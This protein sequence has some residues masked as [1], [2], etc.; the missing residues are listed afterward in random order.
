MT[1][2]PSPYPPQPH[3]PGYQTPSTPTPSPR[4]TSVTVLA[5]I[6]IIFGGIGVLCK[7]LGLVAMFL[8][9]SGPNPM[10]DMQKDM[11]AWNVI[12][13]VIGLAI[14]LLLLAASIGSLSL[15]PWARKGMLAYAAA[16]V[17]MTLVSGV[18]TMVWILPKMQ[19]A[20]KQMIAQQGGGAP[21]GM[22]NIMQTAGTAGAV[23]GIIV[24]LAY[25]LI[26]WYFYTR[27]DVKAAFERGP[28]P[29]ASSHGPPQGGGYYAGQ[30]P[31]PPG[32]YP[33]QG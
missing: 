9:Q 19:E 29:G 25:P 27:E 24:A 23:I 16:A 5:I 6:G 4:P 1:Q 17:V 3:I 26:L 18:A 12:S 31:P 28:T 2:Y 8:P 15:K 10:L 30:A 20:Q 22:M 7:P 14:S 21:A 11:M 33:P 13:T 32:S